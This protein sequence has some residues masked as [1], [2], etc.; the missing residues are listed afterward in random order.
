[1]KFYEL[2]K[3]DQKVGLLSHNFNICQFL[4]QKEIAESAAVLGQL[5]KVVVSIG[6]FV[7]I[8][9]QAY[10]YTFLFIYGGQKL[11]E[12][13]L[14]IT[15]LRCHSFAVVL[16]AINGVTEG[17]VFATMSNKQLNR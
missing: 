3:Y 7:V 15:L 11:T 9:G 8:F 6:L 4:F 17:Y 16:L 14:P 10:S 2:L 12:T 5:C 1:M 13:T